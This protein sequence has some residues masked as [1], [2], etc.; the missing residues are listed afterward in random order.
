M[1]TGMIASRYATALLELVDETGASEMV[2]AQ[3]QAILKALASVPD[4]RRAVEDRTGVSGDR[5]ISLLE[6][7]VK[8]SEGS[9]MASGLR[10]FLALLV[11]NGRIGDIVLILKRFENEYY[12][13]RGIARGRLT[14]PSADDS[15][16]E[17]FERRLKSL[18]E[19][20][21]GKRLLLT[22]VIDESLIGGFRIEVEDRL[23]DAS[24]S[25][26]LDLIRGKLEEKN[27]RI[28]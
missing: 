25:R 19:E 26:Q 22:T 12:K 15:L 2:L 14:L 9:S 6:T 7:V 23:L 17:E 27:R 28:V 8:D 3:S 18:I 13:S 21:T 24:V 11:K 16:G 4:L 5:K 10:K 1:N 20:K